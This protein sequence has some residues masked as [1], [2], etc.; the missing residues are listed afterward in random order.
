M[1]SKR[2]ASLPFTT[3]AVAF[4]IASGLSCDPVHSE[5]VDRLGSDPSGRK[6]GPTH[7]PGQPCL[8]CHGGQGPGNAVFSMAGTVYRD[9]NSDVPVQ[10][11]RVVLTDAFNTRVAAVTNEAGNFY[12]VESQFAPAFPVTVLLC[13]GA[14]CDPKD[15]A[16]SVVQPMKTH[17]GREGSCSGCHVEP[18]SNKSPG[19]VYL[20]TTQQATG[21]FPPLCTSLG[22]TK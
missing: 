21:D 14:S 22:A 3:A 1:T 4:A 2:H 8:V 15:T 11:V 5:G 12:L 7:R 20:C 10:D 13:Y 9:V 19:R 17:I 6:N 16:A 18:S